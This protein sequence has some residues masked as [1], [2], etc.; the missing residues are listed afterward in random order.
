[1][2]VE[3]IAKMLLELENACFSD[4]W[5]ISA[6]EYQAGSEN[7]VIEVKMDNEKPIGYALGTV[8]CGEAELYR[9]GVL[10]EFRGKG[11]GKSILDDFLCSCRRKSAEKV[12]LEVRSRNAPA[13]VLYKGAGFV[14]LATRK[15]YYGDDDA[16]VFE[17]I[18]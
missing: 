7:T 12:F 6:L 13:I 14:Q 9:I 11:F 2:N 8:V 1:M 18:F 17:L 15:G 10:P 4:P 5:N 16:L 3:M